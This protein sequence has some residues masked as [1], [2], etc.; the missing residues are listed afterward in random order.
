[1]QQQLTLWPARGRSTTQRIWEGLD[2]PERTRVVAALASLISKA[3]RPQGAE[4][5][6]EED[7]ER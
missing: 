4:A 5:A 3:M 7:H 1:M 6:A 2:E